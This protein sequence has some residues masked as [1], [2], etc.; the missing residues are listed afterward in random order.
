MKSFALKIIGNIYQP[1]DF[2]DSGC[3][4]Q[5]RRFRIG[6]FTINSWRS[7]TS[8]PQNH[9]VVTTQ[10]HTH[11]KRC[12]SHLSSLQNSCVYFRYTLVKLHKDPSNGL[13][14]LIVFVAIKT[15]KDD[16]LH[17]KYNQPGLVLLLVYIIIS[18]IPVCV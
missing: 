6:K 2:E 3:F 1:C 14:Y 10:T 15:R 13:S 16:P 5:L 4:E 18:I 11:K 9:G 8:L 7:A 12:Y 17:K